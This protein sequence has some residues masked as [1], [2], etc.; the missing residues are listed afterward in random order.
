MPT[1]AQAPQMRPAVARTSGS[2]YQTAGFRRQQASSSYAGG[3]DGGCGGS[4]DS[5]CSTRGNFSKL[6]SGRCPE[7]WATAEALLWF[8]Q[9]RTGPAL[10]S[11]NDPGTDAL[12]TTAG[13]TTFGTELGNNLSAGGRFDVGKYF[14]DGTFGIGG[15]FWI[16]GDDSTSA[17]FQGDGSTGT[18]ARP[19]F[20]TLLG[21]ENAVQI[22]SNVP[23]G[24][25]APNGFTGSITGEESLSMLGAEAYGRLTFGRGREFHTDLLGG[26][27][28]FNIGNDL[29]LDSTTTATLP[30]PGGITT[31][32]DRFN[33]DN[34]FN[35]GQIGSE[36]ILRRGRWVARSLTKVHLGNMNQRV[37]ISGT[38]TRQA[39][40]IAAP[41]AFGD[42]FLAGG[43]N[44][45]Y[46]RDVFTFAPE[47]NL[48][49]GYRFR[50]HVTFNVAIASST[51]TT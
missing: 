12:L 34:N 24:V 22:A 15:R 19:Y 30:S 48:K 45:V 18:V 9:A 16:I 38:G 1:M 36:T 14:G 43:M 2:P 25:N 39:T 41:T 17:N 4:C 13:T 7:V 46:E 32:S 37:A 20:D 26:Y 11:F 35:G 51:G 49:L 21:A 8:P 44:G 3:C 27:S 33:I 42:G 10:A 31:F 29:S 28:Y 23:A 40:A 47:V 5:C 6:M 50:E